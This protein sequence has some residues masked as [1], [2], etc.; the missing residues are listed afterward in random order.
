MGLEDREWYREEM[1]RKGH[2]ASWDGFRVGARPSTDQRD[3]SPSAAHIRA[4][5]ILDARRVSSP[6]PFRFALYTFAVLVLVT[7]VAFYLL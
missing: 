1:R 6:P 7:I 3:A 2:K 4:R 5:E